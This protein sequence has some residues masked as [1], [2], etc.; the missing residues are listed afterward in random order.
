MVVIGFSSARS[1]AGSRNEIVSVDGLR[2]G[3][4]ATRAS[5]QSTNGLVSCVSQKVRSLASERNV[6]MAL[7]TGRLVITLSFWTTH[8]PCRDHAKQWS[9]DRE[10]HGQKTMTVRTAERKPTRF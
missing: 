1:A 5:P 8:R 7:R 3:N 6:G 2:L 9:S 10:D 4:T